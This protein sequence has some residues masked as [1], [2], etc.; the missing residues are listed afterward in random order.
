[1]P[2]SR[3]GM[4]PNQRKQG[5]RQVAVDILGGMENRA[6][7]S[8]AE[9]YLEQTEIE[10]TT[11][12]DEGHDADN[13][14][15][16]REKIE[17]RV[18]GTGQAVRELARLIRQGGWGPPASPRKPRDGEYPHEQSQHRVNVYPESLGLLWPR[19]MQQ[20]ENADDND[21]EG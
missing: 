1:M 15:H 8:N 13:W 6:V 7:G 14:Y 21:K 2:K 11:V 18:D 5:V 4:N 17:Q 19:V 3:K 20:A 12:P 16:E 9:V 10:Y